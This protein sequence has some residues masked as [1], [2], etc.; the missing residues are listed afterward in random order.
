MH[1]I[2]FDHVIISVAISP[3]INTESEGVAYFGDMIESRIDAF[4]LGN[5]NYVC[6]MQLCLKY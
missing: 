6:A 4:M 5:T 2:M 1:I 3:S